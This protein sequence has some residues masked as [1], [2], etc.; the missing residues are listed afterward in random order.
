MNQRRVFLRKMA[1]GAAA[2]ALLPLAGSAATGQVA[3]TG[4]LV[5][6]VFFW[7][8]EP[9]DPRVREKFEAALTK[10]LEVKTI[11]LSHL[12]KPAPTEKRTVV[13]H[14]WDYSLLLFF[15]SGEEQQSYQVDPLH[16]AFVEENSHLWEKVVVYDT[17]DLS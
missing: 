17:V 10:L 5:H 6:H 7:L 12:G 9:G 8:K 14:S 1:A 4:T 16:L 11:R 15:N 13:D 3:L 2:A